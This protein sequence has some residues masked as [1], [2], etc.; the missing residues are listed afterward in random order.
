MATIWVLQHVHC[1]TLG[2]F[3]DVLT[4]VGFIPRYVRTFDDQPVPDSMDRA[5]GL[6]VMGGPMGVG[7]QSQ[8]PFLVEEMRL[9]EQAL[10]AG[11][12]VLGVCLGSQLLA[13]VLGATVSPGP[14]K[15][16]G[17]Y[18]V[19]LTDDAAADTLLSGEASPIMA[20]HWHGDVFDV[21]PDSRSLGSSDLTACQAFRYGSTA[22]GFLFHMEV[23]ARIIRQMIDTFAEELQEAGVGGDT[24]MAQ[25]TDHLPP[26][27]QL[28]GSVI[29]RWVN[30]L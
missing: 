29:Q 7:D 20:L 11:K 30:L 12:P 15:E 19:T 16:I 28:G 14:Q 13:H 10:R 6:I 9:I 8:Y 5:A 17:W 23:T 22:W 26:L 4:D 18:P 25:A 21:P 3:A 2:I 1:E 24:I 27:Q